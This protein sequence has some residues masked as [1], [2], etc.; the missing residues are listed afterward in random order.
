MTQTLSEAE[1]KSLLSDFGVPFLPEVLVTS[2]I[3]AVAAAKE[4]SGPLAMKLCG[5]NVAHKSER[6]LVKLGIQGSEAIADACQ[7]LLDASRPEDDVTGVLIAPMASGLREFIAGI[8]VDPVFG[9]TVVF[10]LGGVLAEAI[11]DVTVRLAPL[12]RYD[13][14]DMLRSLR[15]QALFGPFRGEPSVD[16]D[17]LA[18]LLCALSDASMAIPDL[19]SIDLNPIMIVDG[20]PV[21]LDA[22]V[23]VSIAEDQQ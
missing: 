7:Q 20:A 15:S 2:S 17:A 13:A 6:G 4:F 23:E 9:P 22:L 1:S 3:D 19:V 12:R 11:A 5:S 10:G 14:F 8:S 21:A 18:N 16:T